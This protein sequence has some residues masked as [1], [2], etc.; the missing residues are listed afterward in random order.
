VVLH[1]LTPTQLALAD[2][3]VVVM[4]PNLMVAQL[5]ILLEATEQMAWAA[6]LVPVIMVVQAL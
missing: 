4:A 5:L 3:E 6:V 1:S 2:W